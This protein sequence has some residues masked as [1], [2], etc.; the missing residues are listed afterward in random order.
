VGLPLAEGGRR[1]LAKAAASALWALAAAQKDGYKSS[2][3]P[4]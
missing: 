1:A 2:A 4:P 3:C